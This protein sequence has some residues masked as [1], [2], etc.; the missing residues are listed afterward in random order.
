MFKARLKDPFSNPAAI[1]CLA[2]AAALSNPSTGH[3]AAP[4]R[5]IVVGMHFLC[6]VV[7]AMQ[8]TFDIFF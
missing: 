3:A 7:I 8:R 6:G 2:L 1:A 4:K 5:G